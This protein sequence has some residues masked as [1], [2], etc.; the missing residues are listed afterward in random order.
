M[1]DRKFI[2]PLVF[3]LVIIL[4][5]LIG[6]WY[7]SRFS[8]YGLNGN[9]LNFSLVPRTNKISYIL[10]EI[11]RKY[12]DTIDVS[13]LTEAAIP[14]LIEK[15]DPHSVYIPASE[16]QRFNEPLTGNFSGIGI[17]FNMT[18]DTIA[19]V[20]TVANGPSEM[21]GIQAGDRIIYVDDSLVAGQG[22]PSNDIVKMLKGPKGTLVKVL[23]LRKGEKELL[24]FEIT[25][26]DI[27]LYSVDVAYM[28]DENTGYIKISTFAVTTFREFV[29]GVEKLHELGM[30]KLILD[31]RGNSGGLMDPAINISDQFLEANKLILYY[32]GKAR[33]RYDYHSSSGGICKDDELIILIDEMSASASEILAGALQDNDRGLIMGR[34]SFGKGLVQ[35]HI[36]LRDG[37]AMR[38]TVARYY[39]PTGRSIQK[40]YTEDHEEYY[41]DIYYR[42]EN[43]ELEN[44]DSIHFA[45]SLKY[46][47]PGGR[48]VYGGGGIMP[49]IFIP[50]DTV[51]L[52]SYYS[53]LRNLGLIYR[54]AF[55]YTDLHRSQLEIFETP[56]AVVDY[57]EST[58][59]FKDF[60]RYA[61]KKGVKTDPKGLAISKKI[62]TTQIKANIARNI[63]DN[64]GFYPIILEI[65]NT[66]LLAIEEMNKED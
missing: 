17:Q 7:G 33:P 18:E 44:S 20:N 23:V 64:D 28:I 19:V 24:E 46:T 58:K 38:L 13:E 35:E 61:E 48:T 32:Q 45:D 55:E 16:L 54:F 14:P 9:E 60:L 59:Y 37:S 53:R 36:D 25:R 57:L 4:G 27:P 2:L 31:L 21:V 43:H 10:S 65:D 22:I 63:L 40:P 56:E 11:E 42:F 26:D 34:R 30:T 3:S 1:R 5:I 29:E 6:N 66:L 15:L 50:L 12:V 49:D 41:N 8:G 47:T 52:S 39:T 51:G 62:I